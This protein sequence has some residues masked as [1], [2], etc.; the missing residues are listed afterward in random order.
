[1]STPLVSIVIPTYNEAAG[2]PALVAQVT[3]VLQQAGIEGE[4]VIVDDNSPDG[5]GR[6]ADELAT[7][8]PLQVVHRS[9]KLGL[10]SAVIEGWK[11]ARGQVLG[12]MDADLSHDPGILPDLVLSVTEGR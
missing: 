6:V 8:Y 3:S 2:L 11:A 1:M 10:S 12:V 5:T 9:G 4:V 7:R